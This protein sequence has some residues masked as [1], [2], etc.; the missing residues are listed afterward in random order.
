MKP[1]MRTGSRGHRFPYLRGVGL[2][3]AVAITAAACGGANQVP[4]AEEPELDLEGEAEGGDGGD[5]EAAASDAD[6]AITF[7][8]WGGAQRHEYTEEVADLYESSQDEVSITRE[9]S[10]WD[11][12]WER[13]AVQMAGGSEA[14]II[15]MHPNNLAQYASQDALMSLEQFVDDGTLDVSGLSDGILNAGRYQGELY[16]IS[17]GNPY[18][19]YQY[20]ADALEEAGIEPPGNDWTWDDH[21]AW[22]EEWAAATPDGAPWPGSGVPNAGEQQWMSYLIGQG[23]QP[24]TED[25]QLGFAREDL[26]GWYSKWLNLQEV[27]AI[28][29][30]DVVQEESSSNPEESMLVRER[31]LSTS[32]P[33]NQLQTHDELTDA[34]I[35][36]LPL[37]AGP[38]G[39]GHVLLPAGLSISA[40]AS[41]EEAAAAADFISFFVNDPEAGA[42]YRADNG[43]PGTGAQRDYMLESGDLPERQV[44]VFELFDEVVAPELPQMNPLPE[45]AAVHHEALAR[46]WYEVA[47]GQLTPE[48]AADAF[49]EEVEPEFSN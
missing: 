1:R 12:Y 33:S 43:V 15:S 10:D 11:S 28:P 36:M 7:Q 24:F 26:A 49:F 42:A 16:M 5:D 13:L 46:Y 25:G 9:P 39:P 17:M 47:F 3:A 6:L 48:E 44:D 45:A 8:W 23:I 38:E 14:Q 31:V 29:P 40:N 30:P 18:M 22:L 34:H 35:A 4:E 32:F 41:E 27:G 2:F 20:N 37:P 21:F 19:A